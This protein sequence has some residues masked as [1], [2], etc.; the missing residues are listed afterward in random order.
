ME[1]AAILQQC[2]VLQPFF[3]LGSTQ[4]HHG[5]RMMVTLQSCMHREDQTQSQSLETDR[6]LAHPHCTRAV[7]WASSGEEEGVTAGGT[8]SSGCLRPGLSTL[9]FQSDNTAREGTSKRPMDANSNPMTWPRLQP[10]TCSF[11]LVS[12]PRAVGWKDRR[13]PRVLFLGWCKLTELL[14][15]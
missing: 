3:T 4:S 15:I 2:P 12:Q 7:P 8:N 6:R 14:H 9:E 11:K 1:E 5:W 13:T 10:K